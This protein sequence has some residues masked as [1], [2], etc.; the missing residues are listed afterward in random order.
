VQCSDRFGRDIAPPREATLR[1]DLEARLNA[2][3]CDASSSRGLGRGIL[4]SSAYQPPYLRFNSWFSEPD[5]LDGP[6]YPPT[7]FSSYMEWHLVFIRRRLIFS[8]SFIGLELLRAVDLQRHRVELC[9]TQPRIKD[10]PRLL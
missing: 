1:G 4:L 3:P 7:G 10:P 6:L 8:R 5:A 9:L 2:F